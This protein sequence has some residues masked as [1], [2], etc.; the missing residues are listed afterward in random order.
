MW[1]LSGW[2]LWLL[3]ELIKNILIHYCSHQ[4]L[5]LAL[6]SNSLIWLTG[7]LRVLSFFQGS[8]IDFF[9]FF[10]KITK[11]LFAFFFQFFPFFFFSFSLLSCQMIS[12]LKINKHYQQL[13]RPQSQLLSNKRLLFNNSFLQLVLLLFVMVMA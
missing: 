3:F 12:Q 8:V 1:W 11:H 6:K 2:L 4:L 13:K 10:L 7:N 9:F 5:P